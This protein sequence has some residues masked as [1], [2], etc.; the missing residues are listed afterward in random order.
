M[1]KKIKCFLGFHK[2]K[3][4]WI[5]AVSFDEKK[6]KSP[7]IFKGTWEIYQCQNCPKEIGYKL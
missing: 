6:N 5:G 3:R 4:V 1:I 7:A 2:L